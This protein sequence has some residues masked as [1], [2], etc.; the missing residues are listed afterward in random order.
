MES[1]DPQA[2][3]KYIADVQRLVRTD[4]SDRDSLVDALIAQRHEEEKFEYQR[5]MA[6]DSI[7]LEERERFGTPL[8]DE[9]IACLK[10]SGVD[11]NNSIKPEKDPLLAGYCQVA[12]IL[13]GAL[14]VAQVAERLGHSVL[15]VH[16]LA[17][18]H[19]LYGVNKKYGLE[20]FPAFQFTDDGLLSGF[21]DVAPHISRELPMASV[22]SFFMR[23]N[24][25][26]FISEDTDQTLSPIEWLASR[27]DPTT[28]TSLL[29]HL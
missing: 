27:R 7:P 5:F 6:D 22:E 20:R 15:Q 26:L 14:T 4:V 24:P 1:P 19:R 17:A 16:E 18:N 23:A 21:W 11:L 25:D 10:E 12:D 2:L 28:V 29:K 9:E 13:I 8:S 3:A